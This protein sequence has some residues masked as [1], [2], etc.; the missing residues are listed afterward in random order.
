MM[1]K[2]GMHLG[3]DA[4]STAEYVPSSPKNWTGLVHSKQPYLVYNDVILRHARGVK[5]VKVR[6]AQY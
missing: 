6:T 4:I 2:I 5:K 3:F 1:S